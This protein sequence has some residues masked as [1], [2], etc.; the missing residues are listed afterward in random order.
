MR[1]VSLEEEPFWEKGIINALNRGLERDFICPHTYQRVV[2]ED[3][4]TDSNF[5]LLAIEG[6]EL[7]GV[8]IGVRRT[9]APAEVIEKHKEI[10]WIKAIAIPPERRDKTIFNVLYTRFEELV[11][12]DGRRLIRF[13]DFASWY[14]FPGIDVFYDY[15]L[16]NLMNFGFRKVG[17]VVNYELDL[18]KFYIPARIIRVE[19]ELVHNGFLFRKARL[20]EKKE[21]VSWVRDTFSPFW[22][23]EVSC[24]FSEDSTS[25]WLAEHKGEVVGFSA[26]SVLEP[27]WFGP[28]G[29]DER[30]RGKG[31][32]T[33]L[34]YKAISSLRLDGH[35]FVTIP[36]TEL[37]FFYSQLPGIVSIRHF[38]RITKE[39]APSS[40]FQGDIE[41]GGG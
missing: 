40:H 15:Y 26:Y 3:P 24:G 6:D 12:E 23:Y 7:I 38:L 10:A 25:I 16:D 30:V 22:A 29:V 21:L 19:N 13:G 8:L 1:I 35:R 11:R 14:F 4:N 36:W 31:I 27:D 28:I 41:T 18:R 32:G 20:Q 39:L 37:L 2:K 17:E 34:L 33:V 5:I 9:K